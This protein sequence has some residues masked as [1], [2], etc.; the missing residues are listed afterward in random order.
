MR[1][2]LICKA[3]CFLFARCRIPPTAEHYIAPCRA[4]EGQRRNEC[5]K[6]QFVTLNH[7]ICQLIV[8]SYIRNMLCAWLDMPRFGVCGLIHKIQFGSSNLSSVA[9]KVE[10]ESWWHER[11]QRW[12]NVPFNP[13][14]TFSAC[15]YILRISLNCGW[16]SKRQ[17]HL[18][19]LKRIRMPMRARDTRPARWCRRGNEEQVKQGERAAQP[20]QCGM[21]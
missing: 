9:H 12:A 21:G 6:V 17:R 13:S 20:S 1:S 2:N 3:V 7:F 5:S 14:S 4:C 16:C 15:G 10:G 19:S 8:H 11:R 18:P